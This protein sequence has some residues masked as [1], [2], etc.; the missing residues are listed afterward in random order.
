MS[1]GNV[2][3]QSGMRPKRNVSCSVKVKTFPLAGPRVTESVTAM[4]MFYVPARKPSTE[5]ISD[6]ENGRAW[7]LDNDRSNAPTGC[8]G[9]EFGWKNAEIGGES[10]CIQRSTLAVG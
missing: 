10:E 4:M 1:S 9:H 2:A 5:R 3:W 6:T 8:R 7:M